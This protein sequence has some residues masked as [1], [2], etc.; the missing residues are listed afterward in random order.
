MV[1]RPGH[2]HRGARGAAHYPAEAVDAGGHFRRARS[3]AR[4]NADRSGDT[5]NASTSDDLNADAFPRAGVG[6]PGVR[7]AGRE[8]RSFPDG[9]HMR[10]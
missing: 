5:M 2:R 7:R 3:L 10:V 8:G 4:R 1:D 6:A 9:L